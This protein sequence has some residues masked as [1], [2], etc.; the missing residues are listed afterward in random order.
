ML[1]DSVVDNLVE[2]V[3]GRNVYDGG[4]HGGSKVR[5]ESVEEKVD[6]GRNHEPLAKTGRG[7]TNSQRDRCDG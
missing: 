5:R 7:G 2:F 6:S 4:R 3:D 1:I